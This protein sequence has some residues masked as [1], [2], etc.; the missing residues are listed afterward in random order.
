MNL[1]GVLSCNH[2]NECG[3]GTYL[4]NDPHSYLINKLSHARFWYL[5]RHI[6]NLSYDAML[7][8]NFSY[9]IDTCSKICI[10]NRLVDYMMVL[11]IKRHK[12]SK[13][14]ILVR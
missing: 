3:Q 6:K 2:I 5:Q 4:K 10:F 11:Y 9:K 14:I 1:D 7:K 12:I 13:A 8:F